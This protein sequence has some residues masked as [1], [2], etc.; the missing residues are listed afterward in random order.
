M[1]KNN[2]FQ[3]GSPIGSS[4]NYQQSQSSYSQ[5]VMSSRHHYPNEHNIDLFVLDEPPVVSRV[6]EQY[7][8]NYYDDYVSPQTPPTPP[9]SLC[10]EGSFPIPSSHN[11]E[12]KGNTDIVP[13]PTKSIRKNS[14]HL[15]Y[16]PHNVYR[17]T[18]GEFMKCTSLKEKVSNTNYVPSAPK[19]S[20]VKVEKCEEKKNVDVNFNFNSH[21]KLKTP[22]ENRLKK[23]SDLLD[24]NTVINNVSS[25]KQTQEPIKPIKSESY[26]QKG[27]RISHTPSY[28]MDLLKPIKKKPTNQKSTLRRIVEER[29]KVM[30]IDA[31]GKQNKEAKLDDELAQ[32]S[33]VTN[34][35]SSSTLPNSKTQS[36]VFL[37]TKLETGKPSTSKPSTSTIETYQMHTADKFSKRVAHVPK[38][39]PT[40]SASKPSTATSTSTSASASATT[41]TSSTI[42]TTTIS[43][44]LK[45]KTESSCKFPLSIRYNSLEK[46][47]KELL[48]RYN[49]SKPDGSLLKTYQDQA[50][51]YE[52]N[53]CVR[54]RSYRNIYISLVASKVKMIRDE[55][56]VILN[57]VVIP[58][59]TAK[60]IQ[61]KQKAFGSKKPTI[62]IPIVS[63]EALLT[64]DAVNCSVIKRKLEDM[65]KYGYPTD[66]TESALDGFAHFPLITDSVIEYKEDQT[67]ITCR[68][69]RKEYKNPQI[70]NETSRMKCV[71]HPGR[72]FG[73]KDRFSSYER[74]YICCKGDA[75]SSG[76]TSHDYHVTD[77]Y[78]FT[79]SRKGFVQTFENTN[80]P[81][82]LGLDCEMCYTEMGLELTRVTLINFEGTVVYNQLVKPETKIID[83]NTKFSGIKE[84]DLDNVTI[85]LC[86]VQRELLKRI[87]SNSILIGHSL[88]SDFRALKLYHRC[89]IDT[90]HLFPHKKGLP[91]KRSLRTLASEFLNKIIQDNDDG[92]D[93]FEDAKIALDLVKTKLKDEVNKLVLD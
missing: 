66:K 49:T 58:K 82:I 76:C 71:Y 16:I 63:H 2:S 35:K 75:Q 14:K 32:K 80:E 93:S 64:S 21:S 88:D 15:E 8:P 22:E 81:T 38:Q 77:G 91:F 90:V 19:I 27:V 43:T 85:N 4:S 55:N 62:Q 57:K 72:I 89:V 56:K 9:P 30:G 33:L 59:P 28:S 6:V 18:S 10:N 52:H 23:S 68:R 13:V 70:D 54:A 61:R 24:K 44:R 50:T 26:P 42:A 11:S 36:N 5:S 37:K 17:G 65:D 34:S 3:D 7:W 1:N 78:E 25:S 29:Y 79:Y 12:T 39:I 92:H 45:P 48:I 69:C 51:E 47:Y 40:F 74:V 41:T 46:I 83:Y 73:M 60:E 53:C 87:N 86:D 84:G 31:P 20:D 67:I